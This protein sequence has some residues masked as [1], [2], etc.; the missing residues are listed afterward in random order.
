[1]YRAFSE[2]LR[3]CMELAPKMYGLLIGMFL[4]AIVRILPQLVWYRRFDAKQ[5]QGKKLV[6]NVAY[7]SS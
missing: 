5:D 7:P 3:S 4:L 1:M 2:P 6:F